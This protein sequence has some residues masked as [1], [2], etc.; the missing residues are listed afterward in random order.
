VLANAGAYYSNSSAGF[1]N[2]FAFQHATT[3]FDPNVNLP[4]ASAQFNFHSNITWNSGMGLPASNQI[5]LFSVTLHEF[6]HALGFTSLVTAAGTSDL[7]GADPGVFGVFDTFLER[8]NGTDLFGP[9]GDFV[10]TPADLRS[11]DVYFSG[12][13]ATAANNGNRVRMFAPATF[14]AG[15]SLS[16]FAFGPTPRPVMLPSINFGEVR[17]TYTALD[18]GI[19]EDL[20]WNLAI[21]EPGSML[22]WLGLIMV[23]QASFGREEALDRRG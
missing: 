12:P 2:G 15:Q 20:G 8:G 13:H 19:L 5:D 3:G 17:R 7:S 22:V 21:P 23:I 4:D 16:H 9:G 11:N 10:G 6:T 18:L 1:S 14:Q